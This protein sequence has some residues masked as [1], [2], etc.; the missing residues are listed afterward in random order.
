MWINCG[1][2]MSLPRLLQLFEGIICP[3]DLSNMQDFDTATY[4]AC[5]DTEIYKEL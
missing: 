5:S 3:Q 4:F 2:L 1:I